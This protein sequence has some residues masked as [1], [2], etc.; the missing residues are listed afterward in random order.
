MCVCLKPGTGIGGSAVKQ[1]ERGER[2]EKGRGGG[3]VW[4]NTV[5][6][7]REVDGRFRDDTGWTKSHLVYL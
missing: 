2:E 7:Q 5:G 1:R 3:R 4:H 6:G